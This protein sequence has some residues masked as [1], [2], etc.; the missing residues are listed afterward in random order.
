M[1]LSCVASRSPGRSDCSATTIR[2]PAFAFDDDDALLH[3]FGRQARRRQ[4]DLVLHLHLR[5]VGIGA[6]LEGQRD[7]WRR[8]SSSTT[9]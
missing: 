8:R 3:H 7:R 4:R 5:D 9:S 2:K 6:G 1:S